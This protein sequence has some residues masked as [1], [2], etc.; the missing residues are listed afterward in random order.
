M[1]SVRNDDF[2]FDEEDEPT[3]NNENSDEIGFERKV[4]SDIDMFSYKT[5]DLPGIPKQEKI[6][7]FIVS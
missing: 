4:K 2:E 7:K 5:V 3:E 6:K 1:E